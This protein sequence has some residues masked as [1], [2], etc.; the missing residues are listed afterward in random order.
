MVY[1]LRHVIYVFVFNSTS[2][3]FNHFQ[4]CYF[5]LCLRPVRDLYLVVNDIF[6]H[7]LEG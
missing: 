1:P 5:L 3:S 6:S 4:L 2:F 7:T